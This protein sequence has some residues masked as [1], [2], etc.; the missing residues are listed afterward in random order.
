M[1]ILK[2]LPIR[3]QLLSLALSAIVIIALILAGIY[4]QIAKTVLKTNAESTRDILDQIK[5]NILSECAGY[6]RILK[7]I[8]YNS[9]VQ[10][11]LMETDP[12]LRLDL[13]KK[14]NNLANNMQDIKDGIVDIAILSENGN[15][16]FLKGKTAALKDIVDSVPHNP[17][18]FYTR[19][20][21]LLYEG[22]KKNCFIILLDII[23]ID[24]AK[25]TGLRIGRAAMVVNAGT[26]GLTGRLVDS[27]ACYYFLDRENNIYFS[28]GAAA[29]N[30]EA[31]ASALNA[32]GRSGRGTLLLNGTRYIL[33]EE[34]I[35]ETGG[36][37]LC[38]VPENELFTDLYGILRSAILV[39]LFSVLILSV[40]FTVIISNILS[41]IR[42]FMAFIFRI[43]AG[44]LKGLKSEINLTGYVE[45]EALAEEFNSLLAEIHQLTSRLV[46]AN[47]RLYEAELEKKQSELAFLQSQINPHFLYNTLDSINSLA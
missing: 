28:S 31:G 47:S 17:Q 4:L 27:S 39:F 5:Q 22:Q 14:L 1:L 19:A 40:P 37:I 24:K 2:K 25:M 41:P 44:D 16:F 7:S 36:K 30:P 20:E 15:D 42:H 38:L 32:G 12:L 26:L 35:P 3:T 33:H 45:I 13:F 9:S 8:A 43:K 23:S 34:S 29:I 46:D 18:L 10:D 6:D 11:Y 21:Q